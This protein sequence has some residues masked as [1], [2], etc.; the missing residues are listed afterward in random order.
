MPRKVVRIDGD[1][2]MSHGVL[3]VLSHPDHPQFEVKSAP[4]YERVRKSNV[5]CWVIKEEDNP[6]LDGAKEDYFVPG[7]N[8]TYDRLVPGL[9][10]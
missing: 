1:A 4:R 7:Q 3:T 5:Q 8:I 10:P 9:V 6:L 2:S